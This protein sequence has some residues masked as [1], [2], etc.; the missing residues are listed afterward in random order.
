MVSTGCLEGVSTTIVHIQLMKNIITDWEVRIEK[1]FVQGLERT[2]A[3]G[4][5][6]YSRPRATLSLYGP[7]KAGK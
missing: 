5:G 1:H 4:Q 7:S 2:E 3:L 6:P